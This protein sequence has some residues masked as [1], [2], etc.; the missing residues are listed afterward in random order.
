MDHQQRPRRRRG[1]VA[2]QSDGLSLQDRVDLADPVMERDGAGLGDLAA[3]LEEEHL[4]EVDAGIGIPDLPG[5][6]RPSV[7]RNLAVEAAVGAH[8]ILTFQ[9]G[10]EPS[11]EGLQ[12]GDVLRVERG[13]GLLAH[14]AEKSFYLSL[15]GGV[16]RAC[17]EQ[18]DAEA[19]ADH[20]QLPRA[21]IAAVVDVKS[22]GETAAGDRLAQR[23]EKVRRVV[24]E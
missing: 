4:F 10:S 24:G 23:Q 18:C 16:A 17:V 19:G 9:P 7:E 8:V 22:C 14:C 21:E 3:D 5:G 15:S 2:A 1:G 12:I 11:V 13:Q 6:A 20:G